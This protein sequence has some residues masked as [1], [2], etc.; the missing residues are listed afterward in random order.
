MRLAQ[1]RKPRRA[2]P[3]G[4]TTRADSSLA[5]LRF[6]VRLAPIGKLCMLFTSEATRAHDE[7]RCAGVVQSL[8]MHSRILCMHS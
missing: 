6:C 3:Q 8:C 5:D 2:Q 4:V 7:W 1:P